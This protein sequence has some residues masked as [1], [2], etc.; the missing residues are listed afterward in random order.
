M[1]SRRADALAFRQLGAGDPAVV[2]NGYAATSD[3]WDPV[4]LTGLAT[5]SRVVCPDNRGMGGSPPVRDGLTVGVM[6]NDVI[7]LIDELGIER[8]DVIGW[9]MGGFVAQE[10]AA[11]IPE[12]IGKVVLL[13]TDHGGPGA[14]T[15]NRETW[16]RLIDHG[17]TPRE[18]ATRLL[19]LLFPP[20]IARA[21]DTEFGQLVADARAALSTAALAAQEQAIDL[22]HTE[23]A[24]QRLAA[25]TAP[26]LVVAGVEDVLIPAV[27]SDLLADALPGSRHE[28]F[29]GCGHAFMAQE[30]VKLA[31]LINS[32]FG[33]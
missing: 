8:C 32:W 26:T 13:S 27:N 2:I 19:S 3:D 18:Q 9:S 16:S 11:Q 6:A 23:P 29:D 30:P 33:R 14:V 4:F 17:G 28:L 24:S 12:R 22:W 15:A 10:I 31:E 1:G 25:I 20:A 7:G 5:S 21:M